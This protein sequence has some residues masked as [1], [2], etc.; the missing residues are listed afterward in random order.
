MEL[1]WLHLEWACV[2]CLQ[3]TCNFIIKI[4]D[5]QFVVI[6][7]VYIISYVLIRTLDWTMS[8]SIWTLCFRTIIDIVIIISKCVIR[9]VV[10]SMDWILMAIA[11]VDS[12]K[13]FSSSIRQ[14]CKLLV[15]IILVNCTIVGYWRCINW[16]QSFD[17]NDIHFIHVK[18]RL[19]LQLFHILSISLISFIQLIGFSLC[20][21]AVFKMQT[22]I[23]FFFVRFYFEMTESNGMRNCFVCAVCCFCLHFS[24]CCVCIV[25]ILGYRKTLRID[26]KTSKA[27]FV[28]M[29]GQSKW[30]QMFRHIRW[31]KC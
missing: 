1:L 4:A 3:T 30:F 18:M 12:E 14:V 16:I 11:I 29:H 21:F 5:I 8:F 23:P 22:K 20:C 24:F 28:R 27:H 10:Y 31:S 13:S 7:N 15:N 6:G 26:T 2:W 19:S 9:N 25:C 17:S